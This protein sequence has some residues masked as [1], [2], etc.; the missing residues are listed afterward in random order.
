M[1]PG[2]QEIAEALADHLVCGVAA[3]LEEGLVDM[4]YATAR[5]QRDVPARRVFDHILEVRTGG[6]H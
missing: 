1:R 3:P 4:I 5:V 2:S 6:A